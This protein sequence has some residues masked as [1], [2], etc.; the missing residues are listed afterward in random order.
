MEF[1]SPFI[2]HQLHE[3]VTGPDMGHKTAAMADKVS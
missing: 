2:L 3:S 1:A